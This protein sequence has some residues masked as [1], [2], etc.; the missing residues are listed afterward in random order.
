MKKQNAKPNVA[1]PA[2][3]KAPSLPTLAALGVLTAATTLMT[4]CKDESPLPGEPPIEKGV[5]S[6]RH[7]RG[8]IEAVPSEAKN[9]V[10]PEEKE[11]E[12]IEDGGVVIEVEI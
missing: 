9:P 3:Y 4:G 2:S 7:L 11:A 8:L 12:P 6:M 1:P 5:D 10:P